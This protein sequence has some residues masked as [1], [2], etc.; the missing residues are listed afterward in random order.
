VQAGVG[1]VICAAFSGFQVNAYLGLCGAAEDAMR[2]SELTASSTADATRA[3][4]VAT[5]VAVSSVSTLVFAFSYFF[6]DR[7]TCWDSR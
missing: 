2:E 1:I 7:Q 4:T 5:M 3:I 6:D